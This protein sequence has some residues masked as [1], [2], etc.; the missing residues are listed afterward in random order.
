M[1]PAAA[2]RRLDAP[3]RLYPSHD[4]R[5]VPA[6]TNIMARHGDMM[7]GLAT[8]V[9]YAAFGPGFEFRLLCD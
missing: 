9:P 1:S 2:R 7:P 8:R 4:D 5:D 6:F 3:S